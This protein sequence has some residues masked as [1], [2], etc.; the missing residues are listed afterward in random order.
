MII[1]KRMKTAENV[2]HREEKNKA[3]RIL[4][5]KLDGKKHF[6]DQGVDGNIKSGY[7]GGKA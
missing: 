5:R 3:C 1:I 6:E 2:A 4:V 7:K